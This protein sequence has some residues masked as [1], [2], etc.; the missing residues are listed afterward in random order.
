[1]ARSDL[2]L[3]IDVGT[4]GCKA[5]LIDAE[6]GGPV[7]DATREHPLDTPR[8]M[9]AE[10]DPERW[11]DGACAVVRE[12]LARAGAE[13]RG[14]AAVGLTGQMHGL[15]LLDGAGAALRPAIL[16]NDQR[17]AA[18]CAE[19]TRRVG[20]ARVLELTGNP[21]LTGFTAPKIA[22]VRQHEPAIYQRAA[23]VLLP[24]DFVRYRLTGQLAADVS[25]ASGTSLFDVGRRRWSEDMLAALDLPRAWLPD[26]FESAEIAGRITGP[27]AERCGLLPGTPVVAGAGDQAAQAIGGGILREGD[28]AV[29]LGTSGV[30]FAACDSY[31]VEPRGRLHAFCHAAPGAWHLMGVMLSA[32]GSLRWFR[33]ALGAEERARAAALQRDVYDVLLAPV[34]DVPAGCEGL[35]FL[36]YLTGE[37]TPHADPAARGVFFGLTLRHG[38]GHLARAVLEGVAYGLRDGLELTRGLGIDA[39]Q[40]HLSGGGAA[41]PLWRQILA[42]VFDRPLAL[43]E[44]NQGAAYGAALLAGVGAGAFRDAADAA[45]RCVR[46]SQVVSPGANVAEYQRGYERFAAL[47]PA[48]APHFA[49]I[50]TT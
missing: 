34:V 19:I 23:H 22:W 4:T 30:V 45:E 42:D 40:I 27:A 41:S 36:P 8:P 28:V 43:L 10:Q 11:W 35:L 20:E 46:I 1:M 37:R 7:A 47:Y 32:G 3:G 13:P 33:D 26:V 9:W 25:D 49:R 12:V 39:R 21:V 5:L 50:E 29:T 48:L 15:V 24:K 31:R 18:Q 2:L 16:W 6:D 14:V 38:K 17:T 44:I